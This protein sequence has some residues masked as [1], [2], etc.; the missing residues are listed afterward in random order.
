MLFGTI[1]RC[2]N[3]GLD[4][5]CWN[6]LR[7]SYA[8]MSSVVNWGGGCSKPF[9]E[10]QGVRLGGIISPSAY[11]MFL[12]PLLN[13][14]SAN[15]L[16]L[17]TGSVFLGSPACADD[18]LFLAMSAVELQEMICVQEFYANDEHYISDTKTRV[19]IVNSVLSTEQWN[20]N[21]IFNLNGN[22][23]EVVEECTHLGIQRDST[24]RSDHTRTVDEPIQSARRCAYSLM[25]GLHGQNRVSPVVSLSMWKVYVLPCLLYGLDILT[26]TKSEIAKIN[27]FHK[28]FLKQIMHLPGRTADAAIYILPGQI[29]TEGEIHKHIL[30]PQAAY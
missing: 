21:G 5:A 12:N 9:V 18:F 29:P 4:P 24:S 22:D 25:G 30:V 23:I 14:Y 19:F 8:K 13:L 6:S 1:R 11:K 16:G 17:R 27:Q 2:V 28:K 20:K 3:S 26:L 7:D 10:Q 15:R